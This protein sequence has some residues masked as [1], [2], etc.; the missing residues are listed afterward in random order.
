[1]SECTHD[2]ETVGETSFNGDR[3]MQLATVEYCRNCKRYAARTTH[4][5]DYGRRDPAVV[6]DF[7]ETETAARNQLIA[8]HKAKQVAKGEAAQ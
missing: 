3:W 6:R 7:Q 1:M 5:L 8:A 4:F 2:W